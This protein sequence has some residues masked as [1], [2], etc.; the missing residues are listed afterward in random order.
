LTGTLSGVVN[1]KTR[2]FMDTYPQA[3][4]PC[5][6]SCFAG[7]PFW[8]AN[9][10]GTFT[11]AQSRIT[12]QNFWTGRADMQLS[13]SDSFFFRYTQ[14][15]ADR[16]DPGFETGEVS[17]THNRYITMEETRIYTPALLGRTNFS[18]VRTALGLKDV[19]LKSLG[20]A[21][22][23]LPACPTCTGHT[24]S[25]TGN[26]VPG[27][28][29]PGTI[30]GMGGDSTSPKVHNLNTFQFQEALT[31]SAG[32]QNLK[33]GGNFE[34]IQFN[35]R[36]DFF[37]GGSFNFASLDDFVTANVNTFSVTA[38]G[39]DNN[40]GWRQNLTGMY[41]QDDIS[42]KPGLT[43]N[44]GLRYEFISVPKEVNGKVSTIR[45]IEDSYFYSVK[46]EQTDIGDPMFANPSLK[47]FAP[48][49]GV[50][51]TPFANG[52]TAIRAGAGVYHDQ[53][54]SNFYITSGVRMA[55]FYSA[56]VLTASTFQAATGQLISFPD[57]YQTQ[58]SLLSRGGGLPQADGFQWK[59]D[60][61]TVY[62]LSFTVQQQLLTDTTLEV[63]YSGTRSVHSVRG[64]MLLNTT[65]VKYVPELGGEFI[66]V[67]QPLPN[68]NWDRMRWRMTDGTAWYNALLV[69]VTKRFSRGF[70]AQSSYTWSKS[71]DDSSTW[72][73]SSDFGSGDTLGVRR[74]HWWGRSA[75]DVSHS[76][77]TN[78]VYELPGSN[79]SGWLGK[80]VGGWNVSGILRAF[81]GNP[82][83][84]SGT[85]SALNRLGNGT[86][87]GNGGTS[88]CTTA[89]RQA[90]CVTNTVTYVAGSSVSLAPGVTGL[91]INPG[92]RTQYFDPADLIRPPTFQNGTAPLNYPGAGKDGAA[93]G[94]VGMGNLGRNV[95][96]VPGVLNFDLTLRKDTPIP[97]LG[98][99]GTMEFRFEMFNAANHPRLGTPGTT[100][101]NNR[102][103]PNVSAGII[104]DARGNPRQLQLSLRLVF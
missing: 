93:G 57:A 73:G 10:T 42:L 90:G 19:S 85:R 80:I 40:R 30:S 18:F 65:P 48:R 54:T 38:P 100:I 14:D 61:P 43:L 95:M 3:N 78:F 28:I 96:T 47:N 4:T 20:L 9:G 6:A 31:Y 17:S 60:Q 68:P 56:A 51:W 22:Y 23:E 24:D 11:R 82:V 91:K 21:D 99:A 55:P 69:T 79:V 75:F 29:A 67:E 81:S 26:D 101:F 64:N 13:D 62:K 27:I 88:T 87:T 36:S 34:R 94:L 66:F 5:S 86:L 76:F 52:K 102:G 58:T 72:T 50:A 2:P 45:N 46:P 39:S 92:N 41:L 70:Q 25:F 89:Q 59:V 37:S 98:E 104:Q 33:F 83:T 53:L 7:N 32:R 71:L 15:I 35:Q 103:E 49:I 8:S 16:T 12:N 74:A 63:G 84:P 77:S 1:P 44:V 97:M